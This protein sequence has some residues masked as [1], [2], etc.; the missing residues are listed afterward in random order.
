MRYIY[1]PKSSL[2]K[3]GLKVYEVLVENFPKTF[4]VGGMVRDLLLKN[5][6]TDIDIATEAKPEEVNE[7][8]NKYFMETNLGYLNMGVVLATDRKHTVSVTTFRKDLRA[9]NR[10]PKI[11]FVRTAKEDSKR[12]DFT[13]NSLYLSPKNNKVLDYHKGVLDLKKRVIKF[14]GDP[15]AKIK[16]DPLR[17]ARALRFSLVLNFKIAK[18]TFTSIKKYYPLLSTLTENRLQKELDKIKNPSQTEILNSTI[19]DKKLLDN[20][21]KKS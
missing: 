21:F 11:K 2:E 1:K 3:F 10:Y 19:K 12:R 18:K 6:I 7:I 17:I 14:I 8:L 4:F 9:K 20:Y 15:A 5:K 13:I 16:Q